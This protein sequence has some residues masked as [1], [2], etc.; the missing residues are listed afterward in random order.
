TAW[1][2]PFDQPAAVSVSTVAVLLATRPNV[3]APP[4]TEAS[5][6]RPAHSLVSQ[7]EAPVF[8]A[9]VSVVAA[10]AEEVPLSLYVALV[11]PERI[12]VHHGD[13]RPTPE[14]TPR[15]LSMNR[16]VNGGAVAA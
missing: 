3:C 11:S 9:S 1:G 15:R 14:R 5:T 7:A 13:E 10:V 16:F 8:A 12:G 4:A 6:V 2:V